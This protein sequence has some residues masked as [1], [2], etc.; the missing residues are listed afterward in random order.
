MVPPL[1]RGHHRVRRHR[2]LVAS[3]PCSYAA[4]R[5]LTLRQ[6]GQ[7]GHRTGHPVRSAEHPDLQRNQLPGGKSMRQTCSRGGAWCRA[8]RHVISRWH[9]ADVD[10][11][12]RSRRPAGALLQ[13]T[14]CIDQWLRDGLGRLVEPGA[15]ELET[16]LREDAGA[17]PSIEEHPTLRLDRPG[18]EQ[19]GTLLD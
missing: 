5:D 8:L 19:R 15:D 12:T 4:H 16:L 10:R 6:I 17:Y 11:G 7:T 2:N 3:M 18:Y 14:P 13:P 9:D 1:R